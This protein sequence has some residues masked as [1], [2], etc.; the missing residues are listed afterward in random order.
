MV[1]RPISFLALRAGFTTYGVSPQRDGAVIGLAANTKIG[2][3]TALYA[4]YEGTV[5]GLDNSH[6]LNI[7]IR[8]T[9]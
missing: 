4:R 6:A 8:V 7:G 9:W 1:R 5:S 3:T 2:E